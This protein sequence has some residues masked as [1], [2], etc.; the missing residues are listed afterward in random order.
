[1]ED[2]VSILDTTLRDGAQGRRIPLDGKLDVFR[3]LDQAGIDVIEIAA[4]TSRPEDT[5]P[6]HAGIDPSSLVPIGQ[7]V[8]RL[9]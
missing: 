8:S 4:V 9:V 1:M 5:M 3:R 6:K 7:L 2:N